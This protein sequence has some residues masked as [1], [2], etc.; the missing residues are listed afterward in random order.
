MEKVDIDD[1]VADKDADIQETDSQISELLGVDKR[2]PEQEQ[3]LKELK[4][5]RKNQVQERINELTKA[6]REAERQLER[7]R[8]EAERLRQE[9]EEERKRGKYNKPNAGKYEQVEINGKMFYTDEALSQRVADG[10]MT[11]SEAWAH[12]KAAIKE[13]AKAELKADLKNES[14]VNETE[15]I[16]QETIKEVLEEYPHFNP[17][18]E[19]HNPND[20]LYK[21]ASRLLNNGYA[22]NPRGIKLAIDDAKRLLGLDRKRPD[23]SDEF[24]VAGNSAATPDS[25]REKKVELSEF[26]QEQAIRLYVYGARINPATGVVFTK[27]EAIEKAIKA[28]R[29]RAASK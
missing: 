18:H 7:E 14:T 19:N 13:E 6:R 16:R 28:K 8:E 1:I 11:Q 12:Q 22:S 2:T 17:R 10:V 27:K 9:L 23:V 21:E 4:Q 24:S 3:E 25:R 15:R 29:D 26:E 20:P 5:Q